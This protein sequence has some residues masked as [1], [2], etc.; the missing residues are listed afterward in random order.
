MYNGKHTKKPQFKSKKSLTLLI[1][2]LMIFTVSVGST[3]AFLI[4]QTDPVV[5]TFTPGEIT[6]KVEESFDGETKENVKI[7][8]SSDSDVS[9]Y[10][11]ALVVV[12]WQDESGNVY[13]KKPVLGTDY[14][15]TPALPDTLPAGWIAD[16]NGY[17]Y[18]TEAIDPGNSTTNL[19]STC[20]Q[21][22]ACENSKY[23][24]NVDIITE[25]IQA[26]PKDAVEDAWGQTIA[27]QLN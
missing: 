23:K 20:T 6:G 5:N 21:L 17:Y 16:G 26:E 3:L 24:L 22:Q 27:D 12:S 13:G 10:V 14:S 18:Y 1:A 9:A 19:I 2:L 7:S 25:A 15:M 11:R 8:I 4:T